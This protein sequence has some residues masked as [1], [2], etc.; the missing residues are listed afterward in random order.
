MIPEVSVVIPYYMQA[1]YV[2]EAYGSVLQNLEW[3]GGVQVIIVDDGSPDPLPPALRSMAVRQSN[4]GLPGARNAGLMQAVGEYVVFLD[5][6]DKIAPNY[7]EKTI[8]LMQGADIVY[9]DFR[10]F[11]YYD[12]P[13]HLEAEVTLEK[14]KWS[15]MLSHCAVIRKSLLL[16]AGGYNTR[17]IH[18][19][20]DWDLWID[21]AKRGARFKHIPETL[22]LY[23]GRPGTMLDDTVRNW[24]DW[25]VS[26]IHRNHPDLYR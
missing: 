10:Y 21:L 17:M 8:P 18:G 15:N 9:T 7:L 3:K 4:R 26:Q 2:E 16:E 11:D 13:V 1:E 24:H 22:F 14:L 5:A 20:E 12:F 25:S 19:Y 23:R 6:D